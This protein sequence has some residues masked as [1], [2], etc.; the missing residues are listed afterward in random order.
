MWLFL[1]AEAILFGSLFSGYVILR[2]GSAAWP[3]PIGGFPWLETVLLVGASAA[4][5]SKRSQLV[6]S[7]ALGLTFVVIKVIGDVTLIRN[8]IT[9]ATNVMWACW[10]TLTGVHAVHVLGGGLFTGWLAGPSFTMAA[11]DAARWLVRIE[12]TRRYWIFL[13]LV[14]LVIVASFYLG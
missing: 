13:D 14:W 10:F 11:D 8:G 4:F 5:G 9:P 6:V 7:N 12:A 1:A 2:A 3:G